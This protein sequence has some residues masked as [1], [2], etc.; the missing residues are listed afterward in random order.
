MSVKDDL[1]AAK[2]LIDTPEKWG[3]GSGLR[4]PLRPQRCAIHAACDMSAGSLWREDAVVD[5]LT[6]ALP[7]GFLGRLLALADYNDDPSTT[8]ADIMDVFDRAINAAEAS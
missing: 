1:I 8:H 6:A 7:T 4:G 5:A 3:K 2:A